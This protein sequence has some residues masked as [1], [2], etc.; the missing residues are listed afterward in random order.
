M[1]RIRNVALLA[2][3]MAVAAACGDA[4]T[5]ADLDGLA[6]SFAKGGSKNVVKFT[7]EDVTLE[8]GDLVVENGVIE[9]SVK[10][11]KNDKQ[12]WTN[13][14]YYTEAWGEYL[15]SFGSGDFASTDREAVEDFCVEHFPDRT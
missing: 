14:S 7:F 3:T 2:A 12:D 11:K 1:S 4:P 15:G 6:P 13:C 8:D 10:D 9:G 5:G